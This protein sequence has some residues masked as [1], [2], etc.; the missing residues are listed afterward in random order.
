MQTDSAPRPLSESPLGIR[1]WLILL[2]VIACYAN[3]LRVPFLLDDPF[4]VEAPFVQIDYSTRPVTM[5]SFALNH[6][7][8]GDSTWSYHLLNGLVHA[9]CGLLLFGLL[10]R[11][12]ALV[13]KFT[14][15]AR[16]N[17]AFVT[18]LI[19]V[20][21]PLQTA[22]VTYL[23]Q[24]AESIAAFFY[25]GVLY[26]FV[27]STSAARP[28]RWQAL[29][30]TSLAL[31]F[32][33]KQTIATA[34]L[35][36]FLL[37]AIFL[38]GPLKALRKRPAFYASLVLVTASS[39]L[40]FVLPILGRPGVS[41][42]FQIP[43]STPLEYARTQAGV[44]LHYL[45]L[46]LWPHP[47]C[48]DYAWPIAKEAQEYRVQVVVIAALLAAVAVLLVRRPRLG[49]VASSFFLLLAP[50]SSLMPIRDA[51]AEHRMY[52]A[53][54]P[55]L[56]LVVLASRSVLG[57][58]R[59]PAL[60]RRAAP[61][62]GPLLAGAATLVLA[63]LTVRR[64]ADYA[65][66]ERIW[67]LTARQAPHNP[68]AHGNLGAALFEEERLPEAIEELTIALG[69]DPKA[70]YVHHTLGT[71][72]LRLGERQ[73]A[74]NFLERAA[75]LGQDPRAL[76]QLGLLF[77]EQED[78]VRAAHSFQREVDLVPR[79][80][81]ARYQLANTL[82]QLGRSAEAERQF[83]EAMRLDPA[84]QEASI[85]L[86][87]L[88]A[89]SGRSVEALEVA[90]GALTVLPNTSTEFYNVAQLQLELGRPDEARAS[91]RE[92]CRTPPERAE[93]FTALAE[94][95]CAEAE[96]SDDA[97]WEALGAALRAVELTHGAGP[98]ALALLARTSER[99]A[100]ST[101][102]ERD[103]ELLGRAALF[104]G[105][106]AEAEVL[107]RRARAKAPDAT[108]PSLG[109]ARALVAQGKAEEAL[110]HY[111]AALRSDPLCGEA[112]REMA[113]LLIGIGREK[114]AL[115]CAR[116]AFELRPEDPDALL[117]LGACFRDLGRLDEALAAF[118]EVLRL[119]PA[120]PEACSAV[121]ET[122]CMG[123]KPGPELLREARELARRANVLTGSRRVDLLAVEALTEAALGDDA[124][125]TALIDRAM[126]LPEARADPALAARLR[127]QRAEWS[128]RP[129]D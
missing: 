49:L 36:L 21:H 111:E 113:V 109:L 120:S 65:T 19:W 127:A 78:Y 77:F 41:A 29:A 55:L 20:C 122:I 7:I 1:P 34:P 75:R 8:S 101:A 108:A 47:L 26:A 114:E 17:L 95:L 97:L 32:A 51:A 42:G 90:L 18:A 104:G 98:E 123:E 22:A 80:A 66:A 105:E 70:D 37:D 124:Q 52:L 14:P 59:R 39:V 115:E 125:A 40:V 79:H 23:S 61:A 13:A 83:R 118:R 100:A 99:V 64:N 24:R 30:A 73:R 102:P 74:L 103:A 16:N 92:A 27:R 46:A 117:Q 5:A 15:A 6:A 62:L 57:N 11:T 67:R 45:K 3:S 35:V 28:V 38:S 68:R 96:A 88:L 82:G 121:A 53:L 25:L 31:G 71:I 94:L 44:V 33:V 107:F 4:Q 50:S 63:G 85:N 69:L 106:F 129:K 60:L 58:M 12:L 128:D 119:T 72:Y 116:R 2:A 10:R 76:E 126:G 84:L 9:G 87:A 91:L 48:F 56:L 110:T 54:A 89:V 112:L 81:D 43:D 93:P 86:S